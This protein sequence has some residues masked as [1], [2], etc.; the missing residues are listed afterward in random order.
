MTKDR[1]ETP[2]SSGGKRIFI[3]NERRGWLCRPSYTGGQR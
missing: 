1:R 3:R 2:R